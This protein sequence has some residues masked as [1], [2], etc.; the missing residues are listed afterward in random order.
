MRIQD[1]SF[2]SIFTATAD[3]VRAGSWPNRNARLAVLTLLLL[4]LAIVGCGGGYPNPTQTSDPLV[5]IFVNA[6]S[7]PSIAPGETIQLGASGG[8][9][10]SAPGGISYKDVRKSATWSTSNAAVAR[11]DKGLVT[12]TGVGSVTITATL[13]GQTGSATVVVGLSS[14]L[15]ITPTGAD[16]IS[17]SATPGQQFIAQATYSD[18]TVL[19]VTNFGTWSS[20]PTG[21][22]TFYSYFPGD[23]TFVATGTTTITATFSTG[24]APTATVT[25]V[26]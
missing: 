17:K 14:T 26:P 22:V 11:V 24:E 1:A 20:N 3:T 16:P 9:P 5:A 13:G 4:I 21:I 10:S 15:A 19:D 8:Y 12:G 2:S 7:V 23:A 6:S 25:V 18:G